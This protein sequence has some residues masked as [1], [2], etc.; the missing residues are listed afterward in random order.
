MNISDLLSEAHSELSYQKS[1]FEYH[2]R[3]EQQTEIDQTAAN[4]GQSGQSGSGMI[5]GPPNAAQYNDEV[6]QVFAAGLSLM[7]QL[8]DEQKTVSESERPRDV[9]LSR[10]NSML[11]MTIFLA[12]VQGHKRERL[13]SIYGQIPNVASSYL[14]RKKIFE[15]SEALLKGEYQ[16][17]E[18]STIFDAL[19]TQAAGYNGHRGGGGADPRKYMRFSSLDKYIRVA[20]GYH[21]VELAFD[22][23]I[24]TCHPGNDANK[25]AFIEQLQTLKKQTL[26]EYAAHHHSF[27]KIYET[28]INKGVKSIATCIAI[29]KHVKT[30]AEKVHTNNVQKADVETFKKATEAHRIGT[31]MER[32]VATIVGILLGAF[33]GLA[34]GCALG[35]VGAGVGAAVGAVVGGSLNFGRQRFFGNSLRGALTKVEDAADKMLPAEEAGA[36]CF[37]ALAYIPGPI[38]FPIHVT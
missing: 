36:G 15:S 4:V 11:A 38:M 26:M 1:A 28:S 23:A 20:R 8:L 30:L 14:F 25:V 19:E 32:I 16:T 18:D 5:Q 29:A 35:P 12:Y 6:S 2:W 22:E 21:S 3:R 10:M 33:V 17:E 27:E 9:V 24:A 37:E 34:A 31:V 13:Q 7:Q